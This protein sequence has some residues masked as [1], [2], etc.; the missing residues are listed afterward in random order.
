LMLSEK[1]ITRQTTA[2]YGVQ[3][4]QY[5]LYIAYHEVEKHFFD[6]LVMRRLPFF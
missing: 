6:N 5:T 2:I 1:S 4:E 3:E